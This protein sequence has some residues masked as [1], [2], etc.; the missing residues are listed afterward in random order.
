MS[1]L[2]RKIR[3]QDLPSDSSITIQVSR[4]FK[5]TFFIS[6]REVPI[7]CK[8]KNRSIA[9]V[10]SNNDLVATAKS[11]TEPA[12]PMISIIHKLPK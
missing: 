5:Y 8:R 3:V 9:T 4:C 1:M 7:S 11:V 12:K 6:L 10:A 2:E